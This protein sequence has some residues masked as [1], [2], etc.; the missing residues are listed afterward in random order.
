MPR[1]SSERLTEVGGALMHAC[2]TM[3]M[4][5]RARVGTQRSISAHTGR[6]LLVKP[7]DHPCQSGLMMCTI[8][9]V[10]I[11]LNGHITQHTYTSLNI[12]YMRMNST[13]ANN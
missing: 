2:R 5:A 9:I 8:I 11:Y 13:H 10:H 4:R 1:G 12:H 6:V 3:L 7:S